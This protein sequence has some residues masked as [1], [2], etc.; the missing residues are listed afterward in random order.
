MGSIVSIIV[1]NTTVQIIVALKSPSSAGWICPKP[2]CRL[3]TLPRTMSSGQI[4]VGRDM[5]TVPS[6]SSEGRASWKLSIDQ[7]TRPSIQPLRFSQSLVAIFSPVR[8][9][10]A[11]V[12]G[13]HYR[14][15]VSHLVA[16]HALRGV[17]Y[18]EEHR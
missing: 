4:P 1:V 8:L 2:S 12:E 11:G 3:N 17:W 14:R 6:M 18:R 16:H 9:P 10:D 5:V 15:D 13:P 7:P